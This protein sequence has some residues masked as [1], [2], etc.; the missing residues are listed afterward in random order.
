MN[1]NIYD[2]L[3]QIKYLAK[4]RIKCKSAL[5]PVSGKEKPNTNSYEGENINME[6]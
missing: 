1:R 3:K 5:L 4:V 6:K 2:F